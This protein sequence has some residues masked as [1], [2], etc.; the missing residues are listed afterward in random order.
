VLHIT[1]RDGI[2]DYPRAKVE[3]KIGIDI[4]VESELDPAPRVAAAFA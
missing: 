4:G 3:M 2:P 1:I